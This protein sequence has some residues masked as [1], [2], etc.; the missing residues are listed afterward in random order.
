M[1]LRTYLTITTVIFFLVGLAHAIRLLLGWE[2]VIGG[3]TVPMWVS[4]FGVAAPW[5]L[6]FSGWMLLKKILQE[7]KEA[8]P[9]SDQP[10]EE[11]MQARIEKARYLIDKDP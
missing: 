11:E 1:S 6:A 7:H 9:G 8:T 5:L 10:T 4:F 2:L 3:W